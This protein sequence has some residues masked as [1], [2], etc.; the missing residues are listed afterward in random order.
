M[1]LLFIGWHC[2]LPVQV[3]LVLVYI[4][5]VE[6]IHAEPRVECKAILVRP[7][8]YRRQSYSLLERQI[9]TEKSTWY[10]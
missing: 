2:Y 4:D 1:H 10:E 7:F 9:Q 8:C 5:V 6:R 3:R